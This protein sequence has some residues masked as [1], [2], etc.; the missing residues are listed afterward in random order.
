MWNDTRARRSF[1]HGDGTLPGVNFCGLGIAQEMRARVTA[2]VRSSPQVD[3]RSG[4]RGF[5][6]SNRTR[7]HFA[8]AREV[9]VDVVAGTVRD[10]RW[11]AMT[12]TGRVRPI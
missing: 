6:G 9:I 11:P 10:D 12:P 8:V 4:N 2:R 3:A 7:A 1:H 5:G